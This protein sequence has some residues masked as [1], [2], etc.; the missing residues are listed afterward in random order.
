MSSNNAVLLLGSN[1]EVPREN[2]YTAMDYLESK[3]C[4]IIL[5]TNVAETIPVEFASNYIFCNIALLINTDLSPIGLLKLIKE[6]ELKMGRLKDSKMSG[7][8]EDRIID[9]DIVFFNNLKFISKKLE[10]PHNKNAYERDFAVALLFELEKM[11][12]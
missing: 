3:A 8:Y 1:L 11:K 10:I 9:L 2:L 4:K 7:Q 12:N 6:I 5:K